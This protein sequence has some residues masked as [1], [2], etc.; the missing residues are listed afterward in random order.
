MKKKYFLILLLAA[1]FTSPAQTIHLEFPYF[2]EQTYEFKIFQGEKQITLQEDTIP[3]GGK[4]QLTIPEEYKGYK[5]I[6]Q[7]YLTNSQTGG[8]LDLILNNENFSVSCL[9]SVPTNLSIVY[10]D[11]QENIYDKEKYQQQQQLFEKHDAMLATTR[12]YPSDTKLYQLASKE[13]ARILK[14]YETYS[15]SLSNSPLYAAKFR[16]IVNLTIGIGSI[17]T[18]DEK[19]KANNINEFMVN[20]LDYEVLYT[21]NHWGGVINNWVQLQ[22]TIFKDDNQMIADAK[23]ILS[24]IQSNKVYTSYVATLTKELSRA[25]KDYV[26]EALKTAVTSSKKLLNFEGSLS[27]YQVSLSSKAPDL[28]IS[29]IQRKETTSSSTSILKTDHLESQY[30]LLV[31]FES[32]CGFC[33][34]ALAALKK[35]YKKV[36]AK[37]LKIITISAD[38]EEAV[39]QKTI[40]ELPWTDNYCDFKG[41]S[42]INFKNYGVLGTP[43]MF[44]LDNKG[45]II[46]K[47]ATIDQLISWSEHQ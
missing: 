28:I 2:A 23:T 7:W 46:Q 14:E 32:G 33:E 31:F 3:K 37:N 6:A 30:S 38:T 47:I 4:V 5:G 25:G 43:T 17:I 8:G 10:K 9:D 1:F 36:V 40:A 13:Y 19:E 24:R 29:N 27:V 20:E 22:T 34:D 21:S 26:I 15:K 12:A 35:N 18:L 41:I 44:L 16:Q 39:Y 42:G 45:I 11:T